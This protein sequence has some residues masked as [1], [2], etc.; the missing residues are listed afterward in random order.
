MNAP[1]PF[2]SSG[3]DELDNLSEL[4]L[5][6]LEAFYRLD[7]ALEDWIVDGDSKAAGASTG[8]R[9]KELVG[10]V[11]AEN[12]ATKRQIAR[13]AKLSAELDAAIRLRNLLVHSKARHG[14]IDGDPAIF[15][16]PVSH[17]MRVNDYVVVTSIEKIAVAI[18]QVVSTASTLAS[19]RDQRDAKPPADKKADAQCDP[20]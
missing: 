19:W 7:V 4:K 18:N 2:P 10:T 3:T 8:S 9:L 15:L 1:S 12:I 11:F 13:F 6:M 16:V 17:S 14:T 20:Q 5:K